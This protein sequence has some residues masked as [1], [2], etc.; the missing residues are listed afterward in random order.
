MIFYF[1]EYLT[2]PRAVGII[3]VCFSCSVLKCNL[4]REPGTCK[5]QGLYS[6]AIFHNLFQRFICH[7][8]V[9]LSSFSCLPHRA[10]LPPPKIPSLG[11]FALKPHGQAFLWLGLLK[12]NS[13]FLTLVLTS[14]MFIISSLSTAAGEKCFYLHTHELSCLRTMVM[15]RAG[16]A[17]GKD[18][19]FFI[20]QTDSCCKKPSG[21]AH[22]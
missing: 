18:S 2:F 12:H 9:T 17:E 8:T 11:M 7:H 13:L 14:R 4:R 16:G 5:T 3:L 15:G 6:E 21:L 20:L 22:L 10:N 19:L 1:P